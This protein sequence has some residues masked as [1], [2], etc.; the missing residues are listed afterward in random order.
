ML[1][2]LT[3]S[4]KTNWETLDSILRKLGEHDSTL[5]SIESICKNVDS[6]EIFGTND[7]FRSAV[8]NKHPE[9]VLVDTINNDLL[10]EINEK[11]QRLETALSALEAGIKEDQKS[12]SS[13]GLTHVSNDLQ[14]IEMRPSS[15]NSNNNFEKATMQPKTNDSEEKIGGNLAGMNRTPPNVRSSAG[16]P[17]SDSPYHPTIELI[18]HDYGVHNVGGNLVGM[19]RTPLNVRLSADEPETD[20]PST[21][22]NL[23]H[24]H[25]SISA[26][27]LAT[28]DAFASLTNSQQIPTVPLPKQKQCTHKR[29]LFITRFRNNVTSD[30][31]LKYMLRNS[32]IDSEKVRVIRLTRRGQDV[33]KL[34]FVSFKIETNDEIAEILLRKHFWPT[35]CKASDFV[36]KNLCSGERLAPTLDNTIISSHFQ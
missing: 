26:L 9:S 8:A 20:Q 29:E 6:K 31:I 4:D 16:E 36:R 17:E 2:I 23:H 30:Q 34:S 1:D 12:R 10:H 21:E 5:S 35:H 7:A 25:Q 33:S 15:L 13:I 28:L 19:N 24:Q 22:D 27:E 32:H 14:A 11:C 3:K 18:E